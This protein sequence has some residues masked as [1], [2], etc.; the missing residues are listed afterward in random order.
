VPIL[1]WDASALSKHYVPEVGSDVV[2][3]L[4][5]TVPAPQMVAT[6]LGYAETF[7]SLLRRRNRGSISD[8]TFTTGKSLLRIELVDDPNFDLWTIDERAIWD[9]IALM[10]RHNINATDSAI[11]ALF[12]RYTR[13]H[14]PVH[15]ACVLIA[16]DRALVNASRAEGLQALDPESFPVADVPAYLAAL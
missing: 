10:E 2:D 9:G 11:L 7:S 12:L 3:E 6:L 14:A 5:A 15:P 4:F 1:F 8:A 16:A 13:T